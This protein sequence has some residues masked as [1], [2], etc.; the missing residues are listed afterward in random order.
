MA[1]N[2]PLLA[3]EIA[4]PPIRR[5]AMTTKRFVTARSEPTANDEAVSASTSEIA[6][7]RHCVPRND[8]N[9]LA[10]RNDTNYITSSL[11]QKSPR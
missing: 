1:G 7:L 6:L 9:S 5:V 8:G 2:E 4:F 11:C 10:P 3:D